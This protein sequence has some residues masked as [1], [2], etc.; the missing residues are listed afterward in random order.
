MCFDK[1]VFSE[2]SMAQEDTQVGVGEPEFDF[3]PGREFEELPEA[4]QKVW[5]GPCGDH[6]RLSHIDSEAGDVGELVD[7]DHSAKK[8]GEGASRDDEVI[9][10]GVGLGI[11]A[12]VSEG[13]KQEFEADD[14]QERGKGAAL[15]DSSVDGDEVGF[16]VGKNRGNRRTCKKSCNTVDKPNGHA[17]VLEGSKDERMMNGVKCFFSVKKEKKIELLV[18]KF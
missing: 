10:C 16:V 2:N 8:R 3:W 5:V 9:S 11:G 18:I 14:E 13:L 1:D 17:N 7:D 15:L 6:G 12:L 4:V